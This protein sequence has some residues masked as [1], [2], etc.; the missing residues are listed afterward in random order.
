MTKKKK[1][2]KTWDSA[3][4]QFV[5][6]P[7]VTV[8]NDGS[9]QLDGKFYNEAGEQIDEIAFKASQNSYLKTNEPGVYCNS[10]NSDIYYKWNKDKNVLMNL[11]LK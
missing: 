9:Y 10:T 4:F 2:Y 6:S 5:K 3:K 7:I 8:N 11:D 1:C